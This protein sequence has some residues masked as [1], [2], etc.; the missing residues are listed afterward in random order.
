MNG[1]S[2]V[3][4]QSLTTIEA[5]AAAPEPAAG[6]T[7]A[8][9]P[10][11]GQPAAGSGAGEG[12]TPKTSERDPNLELSRKFESAAQ[13]ESRARKAEREAQAKLEGLTAREKKLAER[14]AELEEALGDPVG[15]LLKIGKDPVE[16]AKRYAQ[17]ET[18][19]EKRIRKLEEREAEREEEDKR[20]KTEW[21]T[22]Q[23]EQAK[24]HAYREF[25]GAITAKEC[26]NLTAL[27][28]AKEVPKLVDELLTR[29]SDPDDPDSPTMVQVFHARKG[30]NP[31][32]K[33]VRECLEYEA[34]LR[35]NRI[36]ERNR[37][38]AGSDG[39]PVATSP[40]GPAQDSSKNESGPNGISNRHA[41]STT[42]TPK[43]PLTLEEKRK[44]K[45]RE[46][47]AAL[48]AEAGDD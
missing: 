14:E 27:Y 43:R 34:E 31:T 21:E 32:D 12:A 25:V 37:N 33:E 17:P 23:A 13:K 28:Q 15:H 10:A 6:S 42:T 19:E 7:E 4:T 39:A 30:R 8:A 16:V 45:R 26:P 3:V 29:P 38:P 9:P 5:P 40:G 46:L 36:L 47:T 44:A 1:T 2:P 20:R 41:A 35:A 22:R 24:Q 18:P 11:Q 48:E